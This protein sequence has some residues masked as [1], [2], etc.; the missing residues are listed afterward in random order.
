MESHKVLRVQIWVPFAFANIL[1]LIPMLYSANGTGDAAYY[2]FLPLCFL[3]AATTQLS[4]LKRIRV[5]EEVP[6]H[7]PRGDGGAAGA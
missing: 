1:T 2:P 5:L 7:Q 3:F 6:G 4:L